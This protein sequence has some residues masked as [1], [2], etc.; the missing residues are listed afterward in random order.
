MYSFLSN[1]LILKTP[2][3]AI[4]TQSPHLLSADWYQILGPR[5]DEDYLLS[6]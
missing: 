4:I 5:L 2:F 3:N 1:V 6:F